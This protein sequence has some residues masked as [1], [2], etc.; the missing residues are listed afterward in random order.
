MISRDCDSRLTTNDKIAVD[1]WLNSKY[2]FHI[3]RDHIAHRPKIM[4]GMWGCRNGILKGLS[5][6]F[7]KYYNEIRNTRIDK[8][9][10]DQAFLSDVIYPVI[11]NNCFVH[12]YPKQRK[13]EPQSCD[14]PVRS[15]DCHMG[16]TYYTAPNACKLL[17][18]EINLVFF[19]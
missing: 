12:A 7:I 10:I 15:D 16:K 13:Y 1:E 9:G 17:G 3:M 14:F 2:D 4:A 18:E 19:K 6:N 8:Y 5:S 11:H